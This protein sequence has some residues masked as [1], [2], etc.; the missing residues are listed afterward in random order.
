[1]AVGVGGLDD[2]A[3][4]FFFGG[5]WFCSP[6]KLI[7]TEVARVVA[8]A[9]QGA[10]AGGG[11]GVPW[12]G[13]PAFFPGDEVDVRPSDDLAENVD[14]VDAAVDDI[15]AGLAGGPLH[16]GVEALDEG[17]E[18]AAQVFKVVAAFEV[19]GLPGGGVYVI[20]VD[21]FVGPADGRAPAFEHGLHAGVMLGVGIK[22]K[23]GAGAGASPGASP[24]AGAGAGAGVSGLGIGL[25]DLPV[26]PLKKAGKIFRGGECSEAGPLERGGSGGGAE[27]EIKIGPVEEFGLLNVEG[28]QEETGQPLLE[29]RLRRGD[30]PGDAAQS[31]GKKE[32]SGVVVMAGF[33]RIQ[34]EKKGVGLPEASGL[35]LT[36]G[37]EG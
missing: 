12:C 27:E 18:A 9:A 37:R 3:E 23:I 4:D 26:V 19:D 22:V 1:M 28:S 24:G 17:Q 35:S 31:T 14:A 2:D 32:E 6:A 20:A 10:A 15:G 21:E 11:G 34:L 30:A 25:L 7:V 29:Q 33:S 13:L 5:P 8:L 36:G 16:G